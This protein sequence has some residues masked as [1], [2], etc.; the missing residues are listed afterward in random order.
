MLPGAPM[1]FPL[2]VGADGSRLGTTDSGL[3]HILSDRASGQAENSFSLLS[4]V[5]MVDGESPP[6][7]RRVRVEHL[8][9][10]VDT[11]GRPVVMM[12]MEFTATDL[13]HTIQL[14]ALGSRAAPVE[15]PPS[16]FNHWLWRREVVFVSW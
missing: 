12:P 7:H 10:T 13:G 4:R 16:T 14:V 3:V 11:A 1:A 9:A 8:L 2:T 6:H 5:I 15:L